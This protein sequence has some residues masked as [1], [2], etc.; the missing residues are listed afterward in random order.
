MLRRFQR[1]LRVT[2]EAWVE[3]SR[4][5]RNIK[6]TAWLK[7][8]SIALMTSQALNRAHGLHQPSSLQH[9]KQHTPRTPS[10]P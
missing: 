3:H 2:A 6:Q 4:H 1:A 10:L 8:K 7:P 5:S 9:P